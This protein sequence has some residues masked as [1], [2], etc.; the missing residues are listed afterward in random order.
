MVCELCL[1]KAILKE[2]KAT[3]VCLTGECK[4][5]Y[6]SQKTNTLDRKS[7]T[8]EQTLKSVWSTAWSTGV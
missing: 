6:L 3:G 5:T 8:G 1:I 7:L 4:A 2:T